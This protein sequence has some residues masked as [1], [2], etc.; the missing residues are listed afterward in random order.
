MKVARCPLTCGEL[1][2]GWFLDENALVSCPIDLEAEAII[3]PAHKLVVLPRQSWKVRQAVAALLSSGMCRPCSIHLRTPQP[4]AKG[5]GTSTANIAAAAAGAVAMSGSCLSPSEIARIAVEVEPSDSTMFDGLCLL[6]HRTGSFAVELGQPPDLKVAVFDVGGTVDT[7]KFNAVDRTRELQRRAAAYADVLETLLEGLRTGDARAVG[8]AATVSAELNQ[9]FCPKP[10]LDR[11]RDLV[12]EV[13]GYGICVAHSGTLIGCLLDRDTDRDALSWL[14]SRFPARFR[15]CYRLR[16]GG[17]TVIA[18]GAE[19]GDTRAAPIDVKT[20][21]LPHVNEGQTTT[22]LDS[23]V[24]PR[25]RFSLEG[26][27][28]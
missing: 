15:G 21:N 6:A 26:F 19:F 25:R 14:I 28:H 27:L 17:V 3:R 12:R 1:I 10:G 13:G 18:A 2:Q 22:G 8:Q 20:S 11:A 16:G 24:G 7:V 4:Y 9:R 23:S 5:F